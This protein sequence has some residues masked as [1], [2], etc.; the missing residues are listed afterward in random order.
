MPGNVASRYTEASSDISES[1]DDGAFT[2]KNVNWVHHPVVP[3]FYILSLGIVWFM[4]FVGGLSVEHCWGG[5]H[6]AHAVITF[7]ALHWEKGTADMNQDQGEYM[8]MT[9]WEQLEGGLPWY[10][11]M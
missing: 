11:L 5:L 6:L 9:W 2:N 7:F 1:D 10:V 8:E 3:I 4:L